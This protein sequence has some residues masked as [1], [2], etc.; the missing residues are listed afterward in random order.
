MK[1]WSQMMGHK[2]IIEDKPYITHDTHQISFVAMDFSD[3]PITS[4]FYLDIQ[5]IQKV[6]DP[7]RRCWSMTLD[8][9]LN[10]AFEEMM[11]YRQSIGYATATYRSSVPPF[12]NFCVKN[13]PLSAR[14]TQGNGRRV[15]HLLS[16][17]CQQQIRL[18]LSPAG[19]H[20]I[21]EIPWI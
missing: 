3:V 14:I 8:K 21:P 11:K 15:A 13:H 20:E 5:D 16:L 12:I 6:P 19:V 4:G 9:K 10:D 17:Y 18:P 7:W 2:S 1:P